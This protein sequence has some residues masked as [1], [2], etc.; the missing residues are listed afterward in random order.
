MAETEVPVYCVRCGEELN[1]ETGRLASPE[2]YGETRYI[3]YCKRCQREHFADLAFTV[4][5]YMAF[6]ICCAAYNIPFIPECVPEMSRIF[7]SFSW[8]VYLRNIDDMD[9]STGIDG[10]PSAFSDG[11]TD[12]ELLF[13]ITKKTKMNGDVTSEILESDKEGSKRQRRDWGEREEWKRKDYNELD[14]LYSIQS[15]SYE[16]NGIDIEMEFNIREICKLLLD[17]QK[18][19]AAGNLK[20]AKEIYNMISKMKADNLMRK[21]DEAPVAAAKIDT[22]MAALERKG[23]AK[24]GKLLP[25]NKLLA[26]L[27]EDHP[28]YPMGK[29]ILDE[30]LL[31]VYNAYRRNS[32]MTDTD[33]LPLEMQISPKLGEFQEGSTPEEKKLIADLELPLIRY[34]E[35]G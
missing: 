30:I 3:H 33:V 35:K 10:E 5:P 8:D 32:G 31:A 17:Y 12:V 27:R 15:K 1:M 16:A 19:C 18:Q 23:Y 7:D 4:S 22:L 13:G 29:D 14:R 26:L 9:K 6:F 24:D 25:Y 11:V 28:V 2:W 21:R 20:E 34:E